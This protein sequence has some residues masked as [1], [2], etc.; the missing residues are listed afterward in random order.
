MINNN[1]NVSVLPN[2]SRT[3]L[4]L[5]WADCR[6][7][8]PVQPPSIGPSFAKLQ[9]CVHPPFP[10]LSSL[11]PAGSRFT[12]SQLPA[13]ARQPITATT[14]ARADARG[15]SGVASV[16]ATR[17]APAATWLGSKLARSLTVLPS[18]GTIYIGVTCQQIR[19][20]LVLLSSCYPT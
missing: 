19:I 8:T 20:Q 7:R 6:T 15:R 12:C 17:T 1:E 10:F 2:F 18:R 3:K 11:P 13:G 16:R 5:D 9:V 4:A 14:R